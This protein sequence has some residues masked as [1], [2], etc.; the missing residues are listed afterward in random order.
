[1]AILLPRVGWPVDIY[2]NLR[3]SSTNIHARKQNWSNSCSLYTGTKY[4]C[5]GFEPESSRNFSIWSSLVVTPPEEEISI[6]SEKKVYD[7]VLKQAAL[8]KRESSSSTVLD[9]RPD[10]LLPG[11]VPVLREAYDRSGEVC[12]EYA[13]TFYLGEKKKILLQFGT[14]FY[15]AN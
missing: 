5:V 11:T 14:N 4:A 12:E 10:L 2:S 6:S 8:V 7:V 15:F 13:K 9:V 3:Y 1:M